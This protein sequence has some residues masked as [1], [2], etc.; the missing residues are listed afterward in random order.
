M[1]P[2]FHHKVGRMM[3]HQFGSQEQQ[4]LYHHSGG[5]GQ[6]GDE[7]KSERGKLKF[8]SNR[9]SIVSPHLFS[10]L[11]SVVVVVSGIKD[12]GWP[13]III[14]IVVVVQPRSVVSPAEEGV[15]LVLLC[16]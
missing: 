6:E 7:Q 16:Y 3:D 8:Y 10:S 9:N 15:V 13:G 11:L 1:N 5:G 4:Q 2:F 14:I 12:E